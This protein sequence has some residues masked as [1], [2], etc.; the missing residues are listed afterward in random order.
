MSSPEELVAAVAG[1]YDDD[2]TLT[3]DALLRLKRRQEASGKT[4]ERC[5]ERKPLSAFSR[6]A[7]NRDGLRRYC[8]ECAATEY[9]K[10][11]LREAAHGSYPDPP[12]DSPEGSPL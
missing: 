10:R 6:D 4:C 1:Q 2:G 7:R 9:Q 11:V 5:K 12:T 8:R 3:E